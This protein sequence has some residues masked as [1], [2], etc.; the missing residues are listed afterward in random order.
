MSFARILLE[1][2]C[3]VIGR[4]SPC[5]FQEKRFPPVEE[6]RNAALDHPA[7]VQ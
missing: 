1:A 2:L 4:W 6:L 3:R 7:I 5:Q